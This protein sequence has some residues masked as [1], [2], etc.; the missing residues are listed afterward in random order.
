MGFIYAAADVVI[1][2]AAG[3]DPS[4]GLPG[5][6]QDRANTAEYVSLG[7]SALVNHQVHAVSSI[8]N[9]VWASRAWTYVEQTVSTMYNTY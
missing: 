7:A 4:R 6:S 2:A 3:V 1:I 9:S 8:Q 5:V